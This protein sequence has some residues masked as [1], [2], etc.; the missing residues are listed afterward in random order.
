MK[1]S[2]FIVMF[3]IFSSFAFAQNSNEKAHSISNNINTSANEYFPVVSTDSRT[4]FFCSDNRKQNI[5]GEDIYISFFIDSNWTTPKIV[6]ELSSANSNE[7]ILSVSADENSVLIFSNGK[8]Y[9]STKTKTGWSEKKYFKQLDFGTWNADA[10]YTTDGKS[11]IFT[12]ISKENIGGEGDYFNANTDIYV[13]TKINDSTWSAPINLGAIINTSKK[14][15][16]PFLHPDMKTLYFSDERENG[17]GSIDVYKSTRLNDTS[18]TEWSEPQNLGSNINTSSYDYGFKISTD[19]SKAYFNT[20]SNKGDQNIYEITLSEENRPD[21]V[22]SISG[23]VS[24]QQNKALDA[25]I[26]WEDLE[27][28]KI[29]GSLK[30]SPINGNYLI[31][32]PF[33]K[34]YGFYVYKQNYYPLSDNVDLRTNSDNLQITKNFVLS[35]VQEIMSGKASIQLKNVFFESN[36]FELKI[37]SYPE[38]NRLADFIKEQNNIIVEISGHT[39]NIGS[40]TYNLNLSQQRANSVKR[41]LIERGCNS[42]QIISKGYGESKPVTDNSDEEQRAKNR[43]VEFKVMKTDK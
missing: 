35:D 6:S 21:K 8:I 30:S 17:Y 13:I 38:L 29:I 40:S 33:G 4:L 42:A 10:C 15:R 16:T 26:I 31:T 3:L 5:G 1:L 22:V 12:S 27:T 23:I 34:N 19:G 24:D 18:W 2:C 11:I 9:E 14:E 25:Q 32:I 37:E 43:R 39:D 20:C 36:K 28:G 7:A 41:Y